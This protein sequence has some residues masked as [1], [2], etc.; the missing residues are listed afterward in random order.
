MGAQT[1]TDLSKP[2]A[3]SWD[4]FT[5]VTLDAAL[6]SHRPLLFDM[7]HVQDLSDLLQSVG[8]YANTITAIELRHIHQ[9]W[10]AFEPIVQSYEDGTERSVPWVIP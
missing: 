6:I 9:N 7:T 4:E 8:R 1:L 10:A 5:I 2:P 3:M